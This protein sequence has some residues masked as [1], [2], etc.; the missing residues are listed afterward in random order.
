VVAG[1]AAAVIA[2]MKGA[3]IVRTHDVDATVDAM[4]MCHALQ[5]LE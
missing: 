1:V 4:K 5:A 3:C 2:V